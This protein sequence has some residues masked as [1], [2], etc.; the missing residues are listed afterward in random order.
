[1]LFCISTADSAIRWT[2]ADS[3]NRLN[4]SAERCI[5]HACFKSGEGVH[6]GMVGMC[7]NMFESESFLKFRH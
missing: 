4:M 1:M 2:V 6:T 3:V 5:Y 7:K